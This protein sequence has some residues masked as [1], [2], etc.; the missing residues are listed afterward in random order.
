M[1]EEKK[2][3][4]YAGTILRI[5][6]TDRTTERI[7]S[8]KYL[9]EL[10]GGRAVANRIF[11]DEMKGAAPALSAE[12]KL[13][14]MTG[15]STGT[16][17]P[18]CGRA[19]LCGIAASTI[20]EQ[21]SHSSI[22]GH[23]A[24]M[25]KYAGYDGFI[26]EGRAE[27]PCYVFIKDDKVSFLDAEPLWGK[28]VQE[29]EEEIFRIHGRNTQALVIGPAGENQCRFAT[30][31]TGYDSAA[32]KGGFGAVF[33]YKN[34]KAIA[35][36]GT[37]TL[38]P[39]SVE[40]VFEVR[41]NPSNEARRPNPMGPGIQYFFPEMDPGETKLA[42]MANCTGCSAHCA[43]TFFNVKNPL[44]PGGRIAITQKCLDAISFGMMIDCWDGHALVHSH[45][46]EKP[47]VWRWCAPTLTD[48]TDPDYEILAEV[49]P[50]DKLG[51][52]ETNIDY[53]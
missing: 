7:P 17:L 14:Y 30:V 49:Y 48:P 19:T 43:Q 9:P 26:L 20:P 36:Q 11:W 34:C 53:G 8:S 29:T 23:F 18:A 51:L 47:G 35:V 31:A 38:I 5:N 2:M 27:K 13:I 45:R 37:G 21:Y 10:I 25:L 46:Q 32:A 24:P 44:E 12:N 50:G 16:G 28:L 6:L 41:D 22:G 52:W 42:R 39:F 4:G 1:S 3:Y 33:G 15:A 40:K